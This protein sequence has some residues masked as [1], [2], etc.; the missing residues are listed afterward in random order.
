MYSCF[1]SVGLPALPILAAIDKVADAGYAAIELNAETLPWAPAHVTP[2]TSDAERQAIVDAVPR[3]RPRD[4]GGR[5]AC[6]DGRRLGGR[7]RA[8]DRLRQRLHRPRRRRR[9]AASSTSCPGRRRRERRRR[10]PGAGSP[11]LSRRRRACAPP[12][13][14]A[15]DRG[16]RRSPLLVQSTTITASPRTC[17]VST[18][19]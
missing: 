17:R 4:P 16:D 19:V 18:S 7:S 14:D 8:G 1:H 15:G 12:R 2:E 6:P 13:R 11:M 10:N 3:P 9:R 5:R